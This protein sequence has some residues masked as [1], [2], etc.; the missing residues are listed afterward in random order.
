MERWR[1][2]PNERIPSRVKLIN[3]A[4][5]DTAAPSQLLSY[6]KNL[7]NIDHSGTEPKSLPA[8]ASTIDSDWFDF[9]RWRA[10]GGSNRGRKMKEPDF[11]TP[12]PHLASQ[13]DLAT[14][15]LQALKGVHFP[16]M[17]EELIKTYMQ[18]DYVE[19]YLAAAIKP[20]TRTPVDA[21]Q[22]LAHTLIHEVKTSY[23][24]SLHHL[25]DFYS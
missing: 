7:Y 13:M 21:L 11:S 3:T 10:E 8:K 22:T 15:Y 2:E 18:E 14:W 12:R 4:M 9:A 5:D 16:K 17:D 24:I 20:G 1:S 25:T 23:R 19:K 6:Y